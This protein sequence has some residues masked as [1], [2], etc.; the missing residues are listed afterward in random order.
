MYL[1]CPRCRL[2]IRCRADYLRLSSCP[3]CLAHAAIVSPLFSSPLNGVELR[4][5]GRTRPDVAAVIASRALPRS[6]LISCAAREVVRE[7]ADELGPDC[8]AD[9]CLLISELATNAFVHG[10]GTIRLSA[11]VDAGQACFSVDDDGGERPRMQPCPDADGGWGL[12]IVDRVASRWGV[13]ADRTR[14][15]FELPVPAR[16]TG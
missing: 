12:Q 1:H 8:T 5:A 11:A 7:L 2:A 16:A 6:P 4:E 9:A 15:W 3:R 10:A 14:V 13:D